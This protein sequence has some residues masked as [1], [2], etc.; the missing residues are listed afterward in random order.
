MARTVF[1]MARRC[2]DFAP[3]LYGRLYWNSTAAFVSLSLFLSQL[4]APVNGS[5]D[6]T[7]LNTRAIPSAAALFRFLQLL[8][9]TKIMQG[10]WDVSIK[11]NNPSVNRQSQIV[12]VNCERGQK[13]GRRKYYT[14]VDT[15]FRCQETDLCR[16]GSCLGRRLP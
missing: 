11:G 9:C 7:R 12:G 5:M 1:K 8:V 14:Q 16:G 2:C 10:K 13:G 15:A 4:R 3:L 6:G